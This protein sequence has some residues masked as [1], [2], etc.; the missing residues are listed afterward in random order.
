MGGTL[1]SVSRIPYLGALTFI[2]YYRSTSN[3]VKAA[4]KVISTSDGQSGADKLR[5]EMIPKRAAGP[6]PRI[7]ACTDG[8]TEGAHACQ[9]IHCRMIS[10]SHL[11][12]L[13]FIV[14]AQFVVNWVNKQLANGSYG[15]DHSVAFIYRT[16]AQSRELEEA[17]VQQNLPYVIFGSATSF[18][19]RQEIKDCLCYLR[20]LYNGRDRTSMLRAVETPKRGIGDT[21]IREFDEYCALVDQLWEEQYPDSPRPSPLQVLFHLSGDD[22]GLTV[23]NAQFPP[24][25]IALSTRPLRL[26]TEFSRQLA[27]L[28]IFAK[29]ATVEQLLNQ[30]VESMMLIPHLDKI[31]K[32]KAEFD[33]RQAI[34][35]ELLQAT[36]RYNAAGPCLPDAMIATGDAEF[37][38]PPLGTFLDDV[39]LITDMADSN[40]ESSEDRFVVNLMTIHASKGMEFDTVFF[41]GV[42]DG[43]LPTSQVR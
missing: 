9:P 24:P 2:C 25:T 19:K 15:K 38:Q 10:A 41:V 29:T 16:N 20:W 31:S 36:S 32:S 6:S 21:A 8:K 22:S 35:Q 27:S 33:E 34:V 17:C 39:A 1:Y 26:L 3:I 30:V 13:F 42:E 12:A 28:R 5:Q 23:P 7:V 18:Y 40:D 43:T 4:Q 11:F 14:L 37:T